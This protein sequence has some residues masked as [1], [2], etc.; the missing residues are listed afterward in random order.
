M[1][2]IGFRAPLTISAAGV[3]AVGAAMV[4]LSPVAHADGPWGACAAPANTEEWGHPVCLGGDPYPD[5][6]TAEKFAREACNDPKPRYWGCTVIVSF[7][8]CGAIATNG[9]QSVGGT[10]VTPMDAAR[11]ALSRLANGTIAKSACVPP[12]PMPAPPPG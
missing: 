1:S 2:F 7:T 8:A 6:V 11:D 10:G 5:K 12:P 3:A 4:A 9:S